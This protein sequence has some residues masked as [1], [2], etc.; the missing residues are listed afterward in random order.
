MEFVF[1]G[2]GALIA[3]ALHRRTWRLP[4]YV[5][6]A[7]ACSGLGCWAAAQLL[8]NI[9]NDAIRPSALIAPASYLI[10]D[11]GCLALLLAGLGVST[12]PGWLAYLG[13]ISYGLYVFHKMFL[14]I[15]EHWAFAIPAWAKFIVIDGGGL[16]MA[17]GTASVSYRVME[18]PINRI[19]ERFAFVPSRPA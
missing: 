14:M 15:L 17:I 13:K 12:I 6:C 10:A 16:L 3:L 7:L 11:A 4:V 1:F 2:T 9:T 5:R 8:G 18:R 19:K